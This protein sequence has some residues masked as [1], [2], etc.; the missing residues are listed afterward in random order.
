MYLLPLI[1][2]LTA[3]NK[4]PPATNYKFLLKYIFHIQAK[5]TN[6]TIIKPLGS[7][8]KI[9]GI[10]NV[11]KFMLHDDTLFGTE[12]TWNVE[13]DTLLRL[14]VLFYYIH[15]Y[16]L[17]LYT[18]SIGKVVIKTSTIND[19]FTYCGILPNTLN[20]SPFRKTQIMVLSK[21]RVQHDIFMLY[22][23]TDVDRIRSCSSNFLSS[24]IKLMLGLHFERHNSTILHYY[25]CGPK[26][27]KIVL[28]IRAQLILKPY[29]VYDGPKDSS[30]VLDFKIQNMNERLFLTSTFQCTIMTWAEYNSIISLTHINQNIS[31][32]ISFPPNEVRNISMKNYHGFHMFSIWTS[33]EFVIK[34]T[35]NSLKYIGLHNRLCRYSGLVVFDTENN[36]HQEISTICYNLPGSNQYQDIYCSKP[37]CHVAHYGYTDYGILN[38][39]L[40]LSAINCKVIPINTCVF[41]HSCSFMKQGQCRYIMD[42]PDVNA[43]CIGGG[44][45]S[46]AIKCHQDPDSQVT[47]KVK[48]SKCTKLQLNHNVDNYPDLLWNKCKERW[49]Y[50]FCFQFLNNLKI[51][52]INNLK[53]SSIPETGKTLNYKLKGFLSGKLYLIFHLLINIIFN[54]K[55]VHT[56]ILTHT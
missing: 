29:N 42:H 56:R 32:K 26:Y 10:G 16:Y 19:H 39:T 40:T 43:S 18:C 5:I 47:I 51:C 9:L 7:I 27:V 28:L 22:S 46:D 21:Y 55:H 41:E 25:I 30:K 48:D 6:G 1:G 52:R 24:N 11:G 12:H 38:V 53:L 14:R 35:I 44:D 45:N 31:E 17:N 8:R 54:N 23:V 2:Y 15:I 36:T 50:R 37:K 49:Y 20:Y 33:N 13:V 34:V 4:Y 3:S